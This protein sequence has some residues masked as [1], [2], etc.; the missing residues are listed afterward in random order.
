MIKGPHLPDTMIEETTEHMTSMSGTTTT[1]CHLVTTPPPAPET[2]LL[3]AETILP[4]AGTMTDTMILGIAT[5][6]RGRNTT[7]KGMATGMPP[8]PGHIMTDPQFQGETTKTPES[9]KGTKDIQRIKAATTAVAEGAE[10]LCHPQGGATNGIILFL[11]LCP[12][13]VI[14]LS[15]PLPKFCNSDFQDNI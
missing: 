12:S 9:M 6:T 15:S 2:T 14:T 7:R 3:P 8:R 11:A 10:V 1:E 13:F 5:M 4:L